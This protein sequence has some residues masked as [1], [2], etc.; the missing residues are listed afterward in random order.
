[1]VKDE[2]YL[3]HW[4]TRFT[5]VFLLFSSIFSYC[6]FFASRRSVD[7]FFDWAVSISVTMSCIPWD[8]VGLWGAWQSFL[9]WAR[10]ANDRK[11][12]YGIFSWPDCRRSF[13]LTDP[14]DPLGSSRRRV[15]KPDTWSV[16]LPTHLLWCKF[17]ND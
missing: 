10:Y 1:M 9:F 6:L 11:T 7:L 16:G 15:Q 17:G 3:H 8:C 2:Y 12:G 4:T 13:C 5:E 14:L